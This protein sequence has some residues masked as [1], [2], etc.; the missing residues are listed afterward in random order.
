MML[1]ARETEA[2]ALM[3]RKVGTYEEWLAARLGL[4]EREKELSHD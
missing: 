1:Q 2:R 4:L 3:G